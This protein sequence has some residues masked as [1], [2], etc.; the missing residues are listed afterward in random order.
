MNFVHDLL[1][2]LR[3][4]KK[5]PTF[6]A[7]CFLVVTLGVGISLSLYSLNK[8]AYFGDI[9]FLD[10]ERFVVLKSIDSLSGAEQGV[11]ELNGFA[12]N[13]LREGTSSFSELGVFRDVTATISDGESAEVYT[14]AELMPSLLEST[15]IQPLVGRLIEESD[16][17]VDTDP[18][19][20]ISHR[21]W[22]NYY[23]ADPEIVG[24]RTRVNGSSYTIIGVMPNFPLPSD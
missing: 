13:R 5:T 6:T 10:G 4:L 11:L 14:A 24:R 7:I 20:L 22:Q 9:P 16:T 23:A 12:I 18:V 8:S 17:G 1:Y 19:V 2:S 3:L 15:G 21:I